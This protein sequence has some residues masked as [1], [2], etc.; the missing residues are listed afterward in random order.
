MGR[1]AVQEIDTF[2]LDPKRA[3]FATDPVVAA[4]A[5]RPLPVGLNFQHDKAGRDAIRPGGTLGLAQ[6][7]VAEHM[8]C[9]HRG[10]IGDNALLAEPPFSW[11]RDA[12]ALG[13]A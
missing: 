7:D 9:P 4:A 8:T 2:A 5:E 3:I 10:G 1:V 11:M 13:S 6:A 12:V